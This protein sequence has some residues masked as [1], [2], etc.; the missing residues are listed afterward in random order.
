M[1]MNIATQKD[2]LGAFPEIQD[3]AVVEILDMNATVDELEAALVILTSDE[4][5]LIEIKLREG[6]QIHRL[7]NILNQAGVQAA[8]DRDR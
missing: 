5:E 4:K 8:A 3:H 6:D 1:L 7:L 2:I